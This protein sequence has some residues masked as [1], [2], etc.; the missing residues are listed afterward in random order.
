MTVYLI[1]QS[2]AACDNSYLL[3]LSMW[4]SLV[5]LA[6]ERL[7]SCE[8]ACVL[9]YFLRRS[10]KD[11][12][13]GLHAKM[14]NE[15]KT[16]LSEEYGNSLASYVKKHPA[17]FQLSRDECHIRLC[18][19]GDGS[20]TPQPGD[21]E[22]FLEQYVPE[23]GW[24]RLDKFCSIYHDQK[25]SYVVSGIQSSDALSEAYVVEWDVLKTS[26]LAR[27]SFTERAQGVY[28]IGSSNLVLMSKFAS[29]IMESLIPDYFVSLY[30]VKKR[31][32]AEVQRTIKA[33]PPRFFYPFLDKF[34]ISTFLPT[35]EVF[36]RRRPE[37]RDIPCCTE[38]YSEYFVPLKMVLS[39]ACSLPDN[40]VAVQVADKYIFP[41]VKAWLKSCEFRLSTIVSLFPR[42][43]D[44]KCCTGLFGTSYLVRSLLRT[45]HPEIC[46]PS[47]ESPY[48]EGVEEEFFRRLNLPENCQAKS[49]AETVCSDTC[50]KVFKDITK[51]KPDTQ[52]A[53]TADR[54]EAINIIWELLPDSGESIASWDLYHMFLNSA[55]ERSPNFRFRA[56][57]IHGESFFCLLRKNPRKF[58]MEER[59]Q[60]CDK[61]RRYEKDYLVR[62]AT[63]DD[64][65]HDTSQKQNIYYTEDASLNEI[66]KLFLVSPKIPISIYNIHNTL[67]RATQTALRRSAGGVL[68]FIQ[69]QS[70]HFI[71][72]SESHLVY[73]KKESHQV[74]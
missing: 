60:Y 58:F 46:P 72:D 55:V 12:V 18:L 38:Q 14:K 21:L 4:R 10:K 36:V 19:D 35:G 30:A 23:D 33:D 43:F 32:P 45:T 53:D 40:F 51:W 13:Q 44:K 62:R 56:G 11:S 7:M 31:L 17:A 5:R 28:P 69:S 73:L 9:V 42:A 34:Q 8:I 50:L 37:V 63:D 39:L 3:Y 20:R 64:A 2:R 41:S 59:I 71:Y 49:F 74:Q 65:V 16:L 66:R 25:P 68:K 24:I 61:Y 29:N 57:V 22:K 26:F 6:P 47:D 15:I 52:K 70:D 1:L 54:A 27:R 67:P 48:G